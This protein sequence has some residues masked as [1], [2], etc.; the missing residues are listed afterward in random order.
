M[1]EG[2]D[3]LAALLQA[4][5]QDKLNE[6]LVDALYGSKERTVA[7]SLTREMLLEH[8]PRPGHSSFV[9]DFLYGP[10]H[11]PVFDLPKPERELLMFTG[12]PIQKV[13]YDGEGLL[14]ATPISP[15]KFFRL[16]P[17]AS[18]GWRRH[19]RRIKARARR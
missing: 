18:K 7:R 16:G 9:M 5:L 12:Q 19:V 15:F 13:W 17:R 1:K 3:P 8:T 4:W 6:E 11:Q 2:Y 10:D 14:H